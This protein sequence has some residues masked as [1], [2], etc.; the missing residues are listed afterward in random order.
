MQAD[1]GVYRA[2][3]PSKL[4][5]GLLFFWLILTPTQ[6]VLIDWLVNGS[7]GEE[8]EEEEEECAGLS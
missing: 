5:R 1:G 2:E 7:G 4:I 8:E 6:P 3:V